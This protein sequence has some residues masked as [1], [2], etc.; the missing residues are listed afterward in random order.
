[1]SIAIKVENLSKAYQIGEFSTGIYFSGF[2]R[3]VAKNSGK[4]RSFLET[5][6]EE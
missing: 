2:G 1:M 6:E 4:R 3:V 5:E